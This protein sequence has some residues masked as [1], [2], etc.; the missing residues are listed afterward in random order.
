MPPP[1]GVWIGVSLA[2][3][4]CLCAWL[5]AR[6]LSRSRSLPFLSERLFDYYNATILVSALALFAA[7]IG[8]GLHTGLAVLVAVF[9]V[10]IGLHPL[11]GPLFQE[12]W[13]IGRY[14]AF[15]ARTTLAFYGFWLLL[16]L[17]PSVVLAV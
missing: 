13:G 11:R 7:I 17:A 3:V 8:T 1:L 16:A 2:L 10:P 4:P 6:S 15:Q 9:T 14:V 5:G 12:R